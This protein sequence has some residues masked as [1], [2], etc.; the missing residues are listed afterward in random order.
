[1]GTI[2]F[3]LKNAIRFCLLWLLSKEHPQCLHLQPG[4]KTAKTDKSLQKKWRDFFQSLKRASDLKEPDGRQWYKW[5][6]ERNWYWGRRTK[7]T[8]KCLWTWAIKCGWGAASVKIWRSDSGAWKQ[9]GFDVISLPPLCLGVSIRRDLTGATW[10]H[11][12]CMPGQA[13]DKSAG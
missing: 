8:H 4:K 1:M 11:L 12:A 7:T 5:A 6:N 10:E 3:R 13:P 2:T 9:H